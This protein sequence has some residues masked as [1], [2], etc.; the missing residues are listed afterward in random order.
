GAS[1]SPVAFGRWLGDAKKLRCFLDGHPNEI[2]QFDQPRFHFVLRGQ[3]VERFVDCQE[4]LVIGIGGNVCFLNVHTLLS[5]TM[6]LRAF[7]AGVVDEDAAHYLSCRREEMGA[8]S[9]FLVFL[10]NE[11]EIGL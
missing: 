10:S 2:T 3:S 1:V 7:A 11:P 9:P 6:A 5:A 4:L 8:A